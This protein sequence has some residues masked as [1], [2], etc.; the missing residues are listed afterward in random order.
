MNIFGPNKL[1]AREQFTM[2]HNEELRYLH[3]S[4]G[5]V[6]AE[7]RRRVRWAGHVART[8]E[9]RNAYTIF[10]L[11]SLGKV[12]LEYRERDCGII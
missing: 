10:T 2:L 7:T 6:R 3:K 8:G 1:E 5:I 11:K 9:T 12:N 4:P